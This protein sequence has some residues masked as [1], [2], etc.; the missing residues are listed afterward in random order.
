MK[1]I[2]LLFVIFFSLISTTNAQ[3]IKLKKLYFLIGSW[4]MNKGKGKL[5]ETWKKGNNEL[6]G[7]SYQVNITGDS[8]L[9]E[10]IVL[11]EVNGQLHFIVTGYEKNNQGTTSFKLMSYQKN[12]F[13]VENKAHDFPQRISYHLRAN[14]SLLAYI[15][16]EMNGELQKVEFPYHKVN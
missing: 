1:R 8:T 11:K 7:A 15:E 14:N 6:L 4:E 16:G 9:T 10:T 2:S 13:I 3:N 12:H 5:I